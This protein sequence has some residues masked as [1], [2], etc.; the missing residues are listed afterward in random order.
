[1][2]ETVAVRSETVPPLQVSCSP[3]GKPTRRQA[4]FAVT[5]TN[6]CDAAVQRW[7]LQF[8]LPPGTH[9]HSEGTEFD[10]TA[11]NP[12]P[13]GGPVAFE[14]DCLGNCYICAGTGYLVP[15]AQ[16]TIHVTVHCPGRD[17]P[18]LEPRGLTVL[19]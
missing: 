15:G 3:M 14:V 10:I 9:S 2:T 13:R 12:T 1:M 6:T 18:S 8:T 19:A 17:V 16:I 5:L 7:A 4:T 11:D